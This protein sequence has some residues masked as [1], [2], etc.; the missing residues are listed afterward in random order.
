MAE[1][2]REFSAGG[3]AVR[4]VDGHWQA[5]VIKPA[6]RSV[7]ALPKGH[8]EP[9]ET[10][11]AAAQREVQEETGL[12]TRALT[13][14]GDVRYVYRWQGRTI[15]KMVSFFLLEHTGGEID[16][17][18]PAMRKEVDLARWVPLEDVWRLLSYSG[19]RQIA[20][21]ALSRLVRD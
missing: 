2:S 8:I 18:T 1:T 7:T 4:R 16:V 12:A 14:L 9:G 11:L 13:K 19:E 15:F 20:R 3:V 17:L 10:A 5:A 21:R 6:G